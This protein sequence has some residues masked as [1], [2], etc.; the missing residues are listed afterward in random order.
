MNRKYRTWTIF[1]I[2]STAILLAGAVAPRF[3][4]I[5]VPWR[6]WIFLA[7]ILWTFLFSTGFFTP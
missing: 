6:P 4:E 5:P 1:G 7:S 2:I 3:F